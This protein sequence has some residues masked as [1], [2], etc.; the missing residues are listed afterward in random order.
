MVVPVVNYKRLRRITPP[1]SEFKYDL[2]FVC[3][4]VIG[5]AMIALYIRYRNVNQKRLQFHT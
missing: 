1:G 3:T 5:L 4:V 2:N